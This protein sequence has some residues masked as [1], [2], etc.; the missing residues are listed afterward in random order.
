MNYVLKQ[1][2][3]NLVML[4]EQSA[5]QPYN[6]QLSDTIA[7]ETQMLLQSLGRYIDVRQLSPG[8]VSLYL[9]AALLA[10]PDGVL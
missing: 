5:Q 10:A 6:T 3:F 1:S 7:S 4:I 2:A 8:Q 9:I